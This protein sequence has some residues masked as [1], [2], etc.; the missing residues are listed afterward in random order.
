LEIV[1]LLGLITLVV[2]FL[3]Q[4]VG[5]FDKRKSFFYAFNTI[6]AGLLAYYAGFIQN[7]YFAILESVWC[8]GAFASLGNIFLKN[9]R[10][11]LR[12]KA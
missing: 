3:L 8:I 6:G 7:V 1:G 10:N 5:V 9:H 11:G 4:S 2:I 12:K